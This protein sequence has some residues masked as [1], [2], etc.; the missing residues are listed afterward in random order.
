MLPRLAARDI[1]SQTPVAALACDPTPEGRAA[2][3]TLIRQVEGPLQPPFI[4]PPLSPVQLQLPETR[5]KA[6]AEREPESATTHLDLARC[7]FVQRRRSDAALEL[8]RS[9]EILRLAR[10]RPPPP[11]RR[12][13]P[14]SND[15]RQR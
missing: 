2:L 1:E 6:A 15:R 10:S 5:L 11:P 14:A 9:L 13:Q 4:E 12:L 8:S 3:F 7:H